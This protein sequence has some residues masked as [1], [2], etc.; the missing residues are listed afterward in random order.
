M[1]NKYYQ[2]FQTANIDL[3][4]SIVIK[5]HHSALVLNQWV[6]EF[7]GVPYDPYD[8]S[9]WKYYRNICGLYFESDTK[10]FI[11]SIDT[12]ERIEFS[13]ESLQ[14]HLATKRAYEFGTTYYKE[15]VDLYPDQEQ[16]IRGVLYPADMDE[17]INGYEGQ[18]LAYP[19][20][21]VESTE[22]SL[23]PNLQEYING[24]FKRWENVQYNGTD[25]YYRAC[26]LGVLYAM[27]PAIIENLR[28]NACL[29]HEA[30]SY[31]VTQ[32]LASH[33]QLDQYIPYMTRKQAMFFYHNLIEIERNNG[34]VETFDVLLQRIFTDRNLPVGHFNLRHS[35]EFMPENLVPVPVFDKLPL[36]TDKNIDGLDQFTLA[37]VFDIE[38]GILSNNIKYRDDQERLAAIS[39]PNTVTPNLPTKLLQSSV[40]DYTG[41]EQHKLADIALQ[42]W[43]W[44]SVNNVY[45]SFVTFTI[46][47]TGTRLTLSSKDAFSF[48]AY[49]LCGGIGFELVKLPTVTANRVQRLP[50]PS[51]ATMRE[52]CEPQYVTDEFLKAMLAMMPVAITMIS[53]ESFRAHTER[54]FITANEQ[55]FQTAFEEKLTAR[56]QKVAA[57]ERLWGWNVISLA[58]TPGQTYSQW[59]ESRNIVM[60]DLTQEQLTELAAIVLAESIGDNLANVITLKDTQRA[61]ANMFLDLSSYS[62]QM[63]LN[64]NSGP[65]L[66]VMHPQ[67]RM[68]DPDISG[69][70]EQYFRIPIAEP[71]DVKVTAVGSREYLLNSSTIDDIQYQNVLQE[72]QYLLQAV[73]FGLT[74]LNSNEI[75]II[76]LNHDY[77][78]GVAMECEINL[79]APNPRKLVIVPGMEKFL[80]LPLTEQ[81]ASYV[82][83]WAD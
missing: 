64:I 4:S 6:T 69:T 42:H 78:I 53:V 27:M 32:Y 21:L 39:T 15:L 38:D 65:M 67:I 41:S 26:L 20:K 33:S 47:S 48:Y 34:K 49:C 60:D 11:T 73:T 72:Q 81:V 13:P 71:M 70:G 14:Y 77:P 18:I 63:G 62:I 76:E 80:E 29:T 74:E 30:H 2:I 44:L 45:R 5:S 19:S 51:I 61:M 55:Y 28:K 9:T 43:L 68:D 40:I 7:T 3:A 79:T 75:P 83:T 59:F 24:Y 35:T 22:P 1:E 37:Q 54:L 66:D 56:G 50:A 17:A 82:D 36:N 46:P 31:H 23:I 16:L 58:D 8:L 57:I 52:V 25:E 10:M 12:L